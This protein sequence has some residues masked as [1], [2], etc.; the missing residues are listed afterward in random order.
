MFVVVVIYL[1]YLE[2]GFGWSLLKFNVLVSFRFCSG[3]GG[4][5]FVVVV[6]LCSSFSASFRSRVWSAEVSFC[7]LVGNNKLVNNIL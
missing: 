3:I 2:R 7:H 4:V 1:E 6:V 5:V